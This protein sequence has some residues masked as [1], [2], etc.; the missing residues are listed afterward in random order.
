M[1]TTA[2]LLLLALAAAAPARAQ[3]AASPPTTSGPLLEVA[4][5]DAPA[6]GGAAD[7]LPG[8]PGTEPDFFDALT[9]GTVKLDA[10]G[11]YDL[12]DFEG[13]ES[14]S[15][16]VTLRTRL[17]YLTGNWNGLQGYV[18]LEDV[19]AA[20][21]EAYNAA[22]LNGVFDRP[23]IAD[24]EVTELNELW[25]SYAPPAGEGEP[26]LN[27]KVGRQGIELD[28]QRFVGTV[29]FR[30]DNQTFDA[31]VVSTDLGVGGLKLTYG[32][33]DQIN[34]VFGEERDFDS[35]SHVVN[36]SYR[37]GGHGKLSGFAYLLDFEN[38]ALN[39]SDTFGFRFAGDRA[40]NDNLKLLYQASWAYQRDAGGN[41]IDYEAVYVLGDVA[42][43]AEGLGTLGVGYE[44]LGSDDGLF[45]FRTPLATLHKFNGFADQFLTT[46]D[47]GLQDFYLYL[48][49]GFLPE[50][51]DAL[52]AFHAFEPDEGDADYGVE[53]D[54]VLT[55]EIYEHLT[56]GVTAAFFVGE[57]DRPDATRLTFD[58]TLAF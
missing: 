35:E 49:A 26:S 5:G 21:D 23:V 39:S 56:A 10:R 48:K 41:P 28:D 42:L 34:R 52:F 12:A 31:G 9:R 8:E 22:G 57:G 38:S 50:G 30:Q 58:L 29:G 51:T 18:E 17:G 3:P 24:P 37:L 47:G 11:R 6:P 20:D 16:A 14:N 19:R 54:G 2:P 44:L 27:A 43:Q 45:G 1:K 7:P 55:Q 36:V 53:F 33:L 4:P 32:F 15:N 40:L 13:F 25:V 46:P